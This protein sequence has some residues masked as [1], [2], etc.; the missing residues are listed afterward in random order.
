LGQEDVFDTALDVAAGLGRQDG[1]KTAV[2]IA[3]SA[4]TRAW[5]MAPAIVAGEK[6]E[7]G[8]NLALIIDGDQG[9]DASEFK[10]PVS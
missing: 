8:N 1:K 5:Q 7:L 4:T 3:R 10:R 9:R 2:E 6:T